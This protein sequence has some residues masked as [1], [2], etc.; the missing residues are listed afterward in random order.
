MSSEFIKQSMNPPKN[1]SANQAPA[2]PNEK[3]FPTNPR[4]RDF[5]A[6]DTE[7]AHLHFERPELNNQ[8]NSPEIN[9]R[10]SPIRKVVDSRNMTPLHKANEPITFGRNTDYGKT[11]PH[12]ENH[13][14]Y[15][16]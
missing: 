16:K 12:H 7:Q 3:K 15:E 10:E 9:Q 4:R 14:V 1:P 8:E 2:T 5:S 13:E 11:T 6:E